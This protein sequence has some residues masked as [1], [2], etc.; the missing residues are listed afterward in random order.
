MACR[1]RGSGT[2]ETAVLPEANARQRTAHHIRR[3]LKPGAPFVAT[4]GSFPQGRDERALWLSRYAAYAVVSGADAEQVSK[5][6][7]A[8]DP[9]V[10]MLSPEQVETILHAAGFSDMRLFYAAFTWCGWI[11]YA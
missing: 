5:A 7:T 6:P 3:R 8:V 2:D 11:A 9:G 10:N 1:K 4:H